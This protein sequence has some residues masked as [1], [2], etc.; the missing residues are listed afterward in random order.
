ML[1]FTFPTLQEWFV[2]NRLSKFVSYIIL[3]CCVARQFISAGD[4]T[5]YN[6]VGVHMNAATI[7]D[8]NLQMNV[9][10]PAYAAHWNLIMGLN[11][12]FMADLDQRA[13]ECGLTQYIEDQ[14]QFPP[15]TS[16]FNKLVW[17]NDTWAAEQCDMLPSIRAAA[18][19]VNPCYNIYHVTDSCPWPS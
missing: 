2:F 11:E 15:P 10:L 7:G 14:L 4:P 6:L 8:P 13:D 16:L 1:A 9:V 12:S 17:Q 5:Y 19:L 3:T 18:E